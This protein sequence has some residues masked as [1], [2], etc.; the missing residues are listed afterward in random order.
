MNSN[1]MEVASG[2]STTDVLITLLAEHEPALLEEGLRRFGPLR[3]AEIERR[4]ALY[5]IDRLW[6]DHLA[7]IQDTRD[8]IHLVSLGGQTPIE[9][10]RKWVT[11]EFLEMHNKVDEAVAAEMS[12]I[13]REEGPIES[14]LER[15]KGPSSTWTYLVNEDQFGWGID[16][17]K[18]VGYAANAAFL[19]PLFVLALMAKRLFKPRKE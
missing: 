9:V 10:F 3:L 19:W 18:N 7:R 12:S 1:L 14:R 11:A 15:L 6:S 4:A 5:H 16:V 17:A 13:L 2:N 8:S